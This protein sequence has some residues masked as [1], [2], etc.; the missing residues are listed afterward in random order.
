MT[1][2]SIRDFYATFFH[3]YSLLFTGFLRY[4]FMYK[5]RKR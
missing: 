1:K 4:P 3:A 5:L 2:K